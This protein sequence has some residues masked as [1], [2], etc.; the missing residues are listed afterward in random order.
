MAHT[1]RVLP[2]RGGWGGKTLRAVP[3]QRGAQSSPGPKPCVPRGRAAS[4]G[5]TKGGGAFDA[6]RWQRAT[7]ASGTSVTSVCSTVSAIM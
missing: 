6:R 2:L 1:E 3:L 4:Y 7:I 5:T